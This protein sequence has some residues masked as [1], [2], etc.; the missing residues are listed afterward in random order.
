MH[1][2][3]GASPGFGYLL[4]AQIL[5]AVRIYACSWV[6]GP[7]HDSR[8]V[9]ILDRAI[10]SIFYN[11]IFFFHEH[12][13]LIS[14]TFKANINMYG[15]RGY[16]RG[17]G[18]GTWRDDSDPL[19]YYGERRGWE[20]LGTFNYNDVYGGRD[21]RSIGTG[22]DFSRNFQRHGPSFPTQSRRWGTMR[23]WGYRTRGDGRWMGRDGGRY[24]GMYTGGRR[25]PL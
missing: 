8:M 14:R 16:N 9:Y 19:P 6:R 5:Q 4:L 21:S 13:F 12:R 3:V 2:S 25:R 11:S 7:K 1:R 10:N 17:Y 20:H 15:Y 24:F 18:Y 22:Y 23:P